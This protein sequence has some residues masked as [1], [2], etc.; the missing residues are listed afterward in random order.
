[1][2]FILYKSNV[3]TKIDFMQVEEWI[4]TLSINIRSLDLIITSY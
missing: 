1:M 3:V 4:F 2:L